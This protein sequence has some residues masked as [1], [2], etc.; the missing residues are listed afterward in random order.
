MYMDAKSLRQ[1]PE[2]SNIT[3]QCCVYIYVSMVQ[4]KLII[5]FFFAST[6]SYAIRRLLMF[7]HF[8]NTLQTTITVN[9]GDD[10]EWKQLTYDN[11][12]NLF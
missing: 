7:M 12:N 2:C 1:K 3:L 5:Y 4:F 11:L 9:V 10:T 8:I 6:T